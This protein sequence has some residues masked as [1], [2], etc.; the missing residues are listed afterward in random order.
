MLDDGLSGDG[1]ALDGRFGLKLH[2]A[3]ANQVSWYTSATYSDGAQPTDP[4]AR[5]SLDQ[6]RDGCAIPHQRI[7]GTEQQ[8]CHR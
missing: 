5:T 2:L 3:G 4:C 7:H 8:L 1:Q 6:P